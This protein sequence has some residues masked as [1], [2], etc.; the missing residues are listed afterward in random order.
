MRSTMNKALLMLLLAGCSGFIE[1]RAADSTL[2]L[3]RSGNV[4]VRRLADVELAREAA[5]GGVVQL[6]VFAAAYPDHRGFRELYAE[7]LCQYAT[8]FVFDDWEAA[9]FAG[10]ADETKRLA[11]RL[12]KLLA[13]C[14]DASLDLLP[15]T[16]RAAAA[17]AD[18]WKALLPS[19]KR[20]HVPFLLQIGSAQ[21]VTLAIAP[22]KG[23]IA[24]LDRAIAT[25]TRCT[26]LAPGFRDAQG[27]ILLGSILAGRSRFFGGPNGEAQLAA[28]R[29]FLGPGGIMVDVMYA[30]G[31]AVAQ[32]NRTL[33]QRSID[34]ALAADLTRWPERRLENELARIKAARYAAAIDTL[35]PPPAAP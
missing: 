6:T 18:R 19:A 20:E 32:Q 16:W 14:V 29:R 35:I 27:E 23:G 7:S 11:T 17:D 12:D 8:G 21:V 3:L 10:N 2:K 30:R 26:E 13:S 15:P 28:A 9:S 5:P 4:A 34:A 31:V 1:K 25:L 24:G 22:L 33:F